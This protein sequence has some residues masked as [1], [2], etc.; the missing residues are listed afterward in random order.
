M[1]LDHLEISTIKI[2]VKKV[3]NIGENPC[4]RISSPLIGDI[5]KVQL[6]LEVCRDLFP[7]FARIIW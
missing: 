5:L 3:M 4:S 6:I 7:N 2:W 1:R